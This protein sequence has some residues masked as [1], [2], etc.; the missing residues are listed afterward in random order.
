MQDLASYTSCILRDGGH[1]EDGNFGELSPTAHSY[2]RS[3]LGSARLM[4]TMLQDAYRTPPPDVKLFVHDLRSPLNGLRGFL[5]MLIYDDHN[6]T[7]DQLMLVK[8][9]FFYANQLMDDTAKILKQT[10]PQ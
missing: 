4:H 10:D 5:E 3:V 6:L 2:I 7:Q 8:R 1:L 9:L